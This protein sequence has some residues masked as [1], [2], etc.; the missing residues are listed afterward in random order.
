MPQP[1]VLPF[2]ELDA[3]YL[4]L[5]PA[6]ETLFFDINVAPVIGV[7]V[8]LALNAASIGAAASALAGQQLSAFQG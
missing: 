5:L 3:Q 6:R 8:A 1:A 4:E 2:D 7:N